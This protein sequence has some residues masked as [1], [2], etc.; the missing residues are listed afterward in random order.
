MGTPSQGSA[1]VAAAR[2]DLCALD[3]MPVFAKEMIAGGVAGA[4]SKTAIAPLERL[5]ILLQTRTNEFRC[6]ILGNCPALGTGP[7]VDL[8]A[9]SASG[10]TA[11][12]C[13]YPLDL[14]R[15]KLAFQVNNSDQPS[16]GLKRP[17]APPSYGGIKM[18]SEVF[19]QK[20][21][22][23]LYRGVGP[24]LMGILPYAGLN[25]FIWT[26]FNLPLD[27]VRRQM[28]VQ[29]HLQHDQS[30][31]PRIT[32]TFQGLKIIK[33]TQGWRQLFAGLSLNY[34]K[35][36][37]SVA[38][39]F[40]AYDTM[41]HLLKIPPRESIKSD[42]ALLSRELLSKAKA[43]LEMH[44]EP[45][46]SEAPTRELAMVNKEKK[47]VPQKK[48]KKSCH[49]H[50][51]ECSTG[52]SAEQRDQRPRG[53]AASQPL[54]RQRR[55]RSVV[56]VQVVRPARPHRG[57]GEGDR[58]GLTDTAVGARTHVQYY[59]GTGAHASER[60][61]WR[62]RGDVGGR[63]A[64]GIRLVLFPAGAPRLVASVQK[65]R[66]LRPARWPRRVREMATHRA[67]LGT[68]TDQERPRKATPPSPPF[69]LFLA[70]PAGETELAREIL[71]Q[72]YL[73]SRAGLVDLFSF[74]VVSGERA[75]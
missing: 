28:Q 3:L 7:V 18:S 70:V 31:G 46:V 2:V 35:V 25:W 60:P 37:P 55:V 5:K 47:R 50:G 67:A 26:D 22:R 45:V 16:S 65:R 69:F 32:G 49:A 1:A 57:E 72:Q 38:I 39:G 54:F 23:A 44:T 42:Q 33:Q 75:N 63:I 4:F 21:G 19:M 66:R 12:L 59:A 30:G 56:A 40:T 36:V 15:T 17:I 51:N 24:T 48:K 6:W 71:L 13:T 29:S 58:P 62:A 43:N 74:L 41:K 68:L 52:P 34:I 61:L 64:D 53:L 73:P 8:L 20:V 11:V 10:G 9:G 14:A 27:V